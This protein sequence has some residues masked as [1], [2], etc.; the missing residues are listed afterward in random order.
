MAAGLA[1]P[2]E[3]DVL[4]QARHVCGGRPAKEGSQMVDEYAPKQVP[5]WSPYQ[6]NGGSV[7][8]V[9]GK[10]F[11]IVACDTRMSEDYNILSREQNKMTALT[12]KCVIATGGMQA[13]RLT[14]HKRLKHQLQLYEYRN[15]KTLGIQ[16]LASLMQQTLYG[17]RFFPLYCYNLIAGVSESGE[18]FVYSFDI[19]GCTESVTHVCYGSGSEQID[20]FLDLK[21]WREHQRDEQGKALGIHHDISKEDAV[22]VVKDAL[23]SAGERDFQTGD[24]AII[25]I[26]TA[27][28][29]ETETMELKRD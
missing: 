5:R 3:V 7:L 18:G 15:Q 10:D 21:V 22:Q 28:G 23:N 11:A 1:F 12:P 19:F 20:P 14:L 29:I 16:S 6:D 13:D 25:H 24:G 4:T 26:I 2:G 8:A 27:N 9:K 17:G